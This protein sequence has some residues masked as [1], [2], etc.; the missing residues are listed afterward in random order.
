MQQGNPAA[1]ERYTDIIDRLGRVE[2]HVQGIDQN[3][4]HLSQEV[5]GIREE[6]T[7]AQGYWENFYNYEKGQWEQYWVQNP[8]PPPPGQY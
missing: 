7:R 3:H 1:T 4:Q 6:Q 5:A 2:L 8:P